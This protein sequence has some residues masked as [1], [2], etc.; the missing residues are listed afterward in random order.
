MHD[1][2]AQLSFQ[3]FMGDRVVTG[4][5][6]GAGSVEASNKLLGFHNILHFNTNL[7]K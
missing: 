7:T 2:E 3:L 4:W 6:N 5:T 1:N